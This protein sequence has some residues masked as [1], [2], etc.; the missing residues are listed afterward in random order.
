MQLELTFGKESM[1]L[2]INFFI[3]TLKYNVCIYPQSIQNVHDRIRTKKAKS[4]LYSI[5]KV[6]CCFYL[7]ESCFYTKFYKKN[8]LI[9][10][11]L[12]HWSGFSRIKELTESI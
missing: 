6:V 5:P 7:F 10:I 2:N 12:L 11:Y 8:I 9:R 1:E 4:A 3:F